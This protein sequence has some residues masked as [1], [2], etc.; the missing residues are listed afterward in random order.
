LRQKTQQLRCCGCLALLGL[1][2]AVTLISVGR[3]GH[4]LSGRHHASAETSQYIFPLQLQVPAGQY[5]RYQ[6]VPITMRLQDPSGRPV[7]TNQPP[8]VTVWFEGQP[9]ATVGN[10]QKLTPVYQP[11]QGLYTCNWPVPWM[12]PPGQYLVQ[13]RLRLTRPEQWRWAPATTSSAHP[14]DKPTAPPPP[15]GEVFCNAQAVIQ[16]A[17]TPPPA[18]PPGTCFATW[19]PDLPTGSVPLPRGGQGDWRALLEW[20]KFMGADTLLYRAAITSADYGPLTREQPFYQH[21]LAAVPGL[22]AEAHHQGLK[23]GVW[24]AAYETLPTSSNAGKPPYQYA[25][26][27]SRTTGQVRSLDFISLLDQRRRQDLAGFLREMQAQP[28]VDLVGLDYMRSDNGGFEITNNF[29][30]EMPVKLPPQWAKMD[31]R[32]RW[33]YMAQKTESEWQT[34]RDFYDQ[35]N[36]YRAHLGAEIVNGLLRDS[37]LQK[38]LFIFVLSWQHGVQHGQDPAMFTDAGASVLLPMLYQVA[39]QGHFES[40]MKSWAG[41]MKPGVANLAPGDQVDD[42]WHQRSRRPA[43]PELLYQRMTAAQQRLIPQSVP[44]GSFIHDISRLAT[45]GDR[46][47]YP[48]TEW[49]LAAAAAFSQVRQAWSVYPLVCRLQA[50]TKARF[51]VPFTARVTIENRS[52]VAIKDLSLRLEDTAGVKASGQARKRLPLLGP[53][54]KI[55]V[56][57]DMVIDRPDGARANRFMCCVRLEWP[58]RDYGEKYRADLPPMF[59]LMQYLQASAS[60]G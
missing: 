41:Y 39:S 15:E 32:R 22:A 56:P 3:T 30:A 55:E 51:G 14:G 47:P 52:N 38:P 12:A 27:I 7:V 46:G 43:T 10:L 59:V 20:A 6:L 36:W 50:P 42:R 16:V 57:L 17:A 58:R 53:G 5:T 1:A 19:E 18:Y 9:V 21:E 25:Q 34:D 23:F 2:L 40:V 49:A 13:A 45:R 35:W 48:G 31:Q 29:A 60:G 37:Q 8:Q 4:W 26:D 24:A 11:D 33:Q 54:E 28:D 44:L